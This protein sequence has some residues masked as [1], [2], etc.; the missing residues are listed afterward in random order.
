MTNNT[1]NN[2]IN[3][4]FLNCIGLGARHLQWL[5]HQRSDILF[6]QE[7]HFTPAITM[8]LENEFIEWELVHSFGE[9]NARGC[10]IR[11]KKK[12]TIFSLIRTDNTY[13]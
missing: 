3:L 8:S 12:Y 10:S 7:T 4:L 6:I 1:I 13:S 2:T 11:I 9:S 5:N